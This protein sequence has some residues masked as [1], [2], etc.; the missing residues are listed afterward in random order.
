MVY[1][2]L[3]SYLKMHK[4]LNLPIHPTILQMNKLICI[5]VFLIFLPILISAQTTSNAA[6]LEDLLNTSSVTCAQAAMFVLN[7]T[8]KIFSDSAF[9]YA[10]SKGWLKKVK[11]YDPIKLSQLSFLIMNAF[12]LNGGM[13]YRLI[14]SPRYAY[15]NLVS[16]S[17]IQ[18]MTDP[19]MKVSGEHFLLILGK[20]LNAAGEEM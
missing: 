13:M 11:P 17:W 15:R 14:P 1:S 19:A 16:R 10:S 4:I 8:D 2:S 7:S 3:R 5:T 18:G 9:D 6:E 20:D 12:E